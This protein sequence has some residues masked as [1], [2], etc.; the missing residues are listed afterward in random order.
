MS[1]EPRKSAPE[2]TQPEAGSRQIQ[3]GNPFLKLVTPRFAVQAAPLFH[4]WRP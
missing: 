4:A 3:R 1:V 2:G